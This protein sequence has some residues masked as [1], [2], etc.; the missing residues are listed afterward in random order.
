MILQIGS[1]G[2][3][4]KQLQAYLHLAQDGIFGKITKEAVIAFQKANSLKADGIVGD[5]TWTVLK[6][7]YGTPQTGLKKT[8]RKIKNIIVHCSATAEGKDYTVDDITRWHKQ[9]GYATIGYHY[10]IYRDG[11][12][13]EG[14][15]ID[16]IGAH[17]EGHN[18]GSIGICYI[19]GLA[20]DNKTAKDTRT[21]AQE[22]ALVDLVKKLKDMY[23][24]TPE[25]IHGHYEFA[26]KA[27]PSFRID[28]VREAVR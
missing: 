14:R 17:C 23:L 12:V 3:E 10:V 25:A 13:H 16:T 6:A 18:T 21:D 27:C 22:K 26:N 7:I 15:N 4:V 1:R 11:S 24:L 20:S 2:N 28:S 8:A 19:G 9:R 5:K